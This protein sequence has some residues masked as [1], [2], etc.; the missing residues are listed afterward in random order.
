[1]GTRRHFETFCPGP[2]KEASGNTTSSWTSG[3]WSLVFTYV[4]LVLTPSSSQRT[5]S[6]KQN[7]AFWLTAWW[8]W[9]LHEPTWLFSPPARGSAPSCP[10][11]Q[12]LSCSWRQ[13]LIECFKKG[14]EQLQRQTVWC[15]VSSGSGCSAFLLRFCWLLLQEH[16]F[17][18]LTEQWKSS[19]RVIKHL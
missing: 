15:S 14:S 10:P 6:R 17:T 1:M 7:G 8:F 18:S 16:V 5:V 4:V 2:L 12:T 3:L 13:V 19:A 11:E 9:T